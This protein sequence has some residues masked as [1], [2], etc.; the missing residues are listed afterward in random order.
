[1]ITPI[2][3]CHSC[4]TAVCLPCP[5][6]RHMFDG[7]RGT[8]IISP[9]H[10]GW[11]AVLTAACRAEP[12]RLRFDAAGVMQCSKGVSMDANYLALVEAV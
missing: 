9:E 11:P 2:T 8:K 7:M 1:M 5:R 4:S 6:P 10:G 3:S 12:R